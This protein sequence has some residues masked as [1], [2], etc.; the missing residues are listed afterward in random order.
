VG[1]RNA[2]GR[3]YLPDLQTPERGLCKNLSSGL[4]VI[5]LLV[6]HS[7]DQEAKAEKELLLVEQ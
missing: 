2:P 7:I 1:R 4:F 3:F 5:M 6:T